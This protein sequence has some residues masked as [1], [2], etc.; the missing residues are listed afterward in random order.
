MLCNQSN[1]FKKYSVVNDLKK[2]QLKYFC[3][4]NLR[5]SN[6]N[7]IVQL[8]LYLFKIKNLYYL[9]SI[10]CL[11][12][13]LSISYNY[14]LMSEA[15]LSQLYEGVLNR[16]QIQETIAFVK[17][18]EW[19]FILLNVLIVFIRISFVAI[20]LY[21][22]L[23]FFSN[24]SNPF[25]TTFNI[26]LKAEIIFVVYTIVR[27]LW[28]GVI[29]IPEAPEEMQVTPLSL[30]HFF[31]PHF[32]EPWLI[33]PLSTLNIFEGL[34]FLMLSALMAATVQIKFR[35]AFELVFVSYG[36]GLLLLMVTQMFLILNNT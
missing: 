34:Y 7:L 18:W 6:L 35:K 5:G 11:Y 12:V 30:M 19:G 16:T 21:L 23:F 28:F 20:C 13:I 26:A 29:N 9:I 33:Y 24:Q 3:N 32:I 36:T 2:H 8:M 31:D 27:L 1:V 14:F 10:I 15:L 4:V 17:K 22:G 25:K